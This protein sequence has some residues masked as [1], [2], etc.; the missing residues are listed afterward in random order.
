M[1]AHGK[2]VREEGPGSQQNLARKRRE[3]LRDGPIGVIGHKGYRD[4]REDRDMTTCLNVS[5]A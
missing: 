4:H 1:R 5:P 2:S 3:L